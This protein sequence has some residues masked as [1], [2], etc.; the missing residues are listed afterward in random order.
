MSA[1]VQ[2]T[3]RAMFG[4]YRWIPWVIVACFLA[5]V[6]VNGGLVYFA[7]ESWPGLTTDH[8]YNEGLAYN[9][10]IAET[11]KEA[12]LGWT[13][14]IDFAPRGADSGKLIVTMRG[15]DGRPLDGLSLSGELVRPVEQMPPVPLAFAGNGD[16]LYVAQVAIPRPGQWDV[17]L[18]ARRGDDA[19]RGG[20]RIVAAPK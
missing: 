15:A 16:G 2:R 5:V 20:K 4:N 1:F 19:L 18:V 3:R 14:N 11:E 9:A 6:A 8:A 10:V 7:A 17:F 12:K 13:M